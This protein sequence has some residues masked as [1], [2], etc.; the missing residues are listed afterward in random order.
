MVNLHMTILKR[1]T[2][3]DR[4]IMWNGTVPIETLAHNIQ[5]AIIILVLCFAQMTSMSKCA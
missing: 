5:Y 2:K 1:T 3:V 4:H